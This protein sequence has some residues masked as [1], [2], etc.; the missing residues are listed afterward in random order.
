[1]K[2]MALDRH[3]RFATVAEFE[4]GI[5]Q[6]KKVLTPEK[7]VKQRKRRR[8]LGV[9]TGVLVLATGAFVFLVNLNKQHEAETL[10]D[11]QMELWY[12]ATG[13]ADADRATEEALDGILE[14]FTTSFP[15]VQIIPVEKPANGYAAAVSE[16]LAA[17]KPLIFEADGLSASD[18]AGAL[19]LSPALNQ[20][21]N[22][23]CYF[24]DKYVSYFPDK[25]RLPTG[26]VAPVLYVNMTKSLAAGPG[27]R[28]T[29][30]TGASKAEFLAGEAESYLGTSAEYFDVQAA[31]PARYRLLYLD[32]NSVRG[33][34]NGLWAASPG[35]KDEQKVEL[36]FLRYLLSDNA[37]DYLHIRRRSG[38]LPLNIRALGT[39]CEVYNDFDGFFANVDKYTF[40]TE[41]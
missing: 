32:Q 21:E 38:A 3:L 11:A 15:N 14:A 29:E 19:D 13:N 36:R 18:L 20:T 30:N 28:S 31:L 37:Q 23:D 33:E 24:L 22:T 1:M 7:E 16:T 6:E 4:Q 8:L 12:Q 34:F 26:F 25:R 2:A 17:G 27:S 35:D 9:L 41:S 40:Q 10:P 39:Y 5:R